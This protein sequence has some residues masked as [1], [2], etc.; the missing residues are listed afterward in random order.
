VCQGTQFYKSKHFKPKSKSPG[1]EETNLKNK[2]A[3]HDRKRL[4]RQKK[5]RKSRK[6][7]NGNRPCAMEA[8]R[9]KQ[10][11]LLCSSALSK[12]ATNSPPKRV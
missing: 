2:L 8:E 3:E 6:Q 1:K 11:I 4:V 10:P 5:T 9:G 12:N 7:K